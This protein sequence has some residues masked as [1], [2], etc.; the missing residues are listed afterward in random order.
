MPLTK[1]APAALKRARVADGGAGPV[2]VPAGERGRDVVVVARGDAEPDHVDQQVLAFARTRR[3]AAAPHRAPIAA[4]PTGFGDGDF[5]QFSVHGS[6][7]RVAQAR[8]LAETGDAVDGDDDGEGDDQHDQAEHRD[9]AE[10][11]RIR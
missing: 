3:Q 7:Q 2:V 8:T 1:A 5:R 4:S 9:G 6:R 10:I 11:A